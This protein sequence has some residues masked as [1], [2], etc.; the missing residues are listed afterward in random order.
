MFLDN[1]KGYGKII[2]LE[3]IGTEKNKEKIYNDLK[4]K[5]LT[6]GIKKITPKKE[7]DKK[8]KYY[9]NNWQKILKYE[10]R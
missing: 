2:E 7:F 5:L 9:K 8:F 3:K 4:A 10:R 6:L 1:T